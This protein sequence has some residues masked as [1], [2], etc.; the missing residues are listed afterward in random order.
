MVK[1]RLFRLSNGGT[2]ERR[3]PCDR[4]FRFEKRGRLAAR[5]L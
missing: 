2:C 3:S 4:S 1:K 5:L